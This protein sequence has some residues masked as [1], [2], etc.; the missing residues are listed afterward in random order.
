[1]IWEYLN[2]EPKIY[3]MGLIWDPKEN[4]ISDPKRDLTSNN[5]T[6]LGTVNHPIC[7]WQAACKVCFVSFWFLLR[8]FL[9]PYYMN[10]DDVIQL[11]AT[12]TELKEFLN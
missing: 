6:T 10:T 12:E 9:Y 5:P 11:D 3:T 8:Y 4:A 1:M 7:Q 2:I